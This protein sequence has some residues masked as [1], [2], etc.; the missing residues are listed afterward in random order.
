MFSAPL[1]RQF[2]NASRS[3]RTT[4][5]RWASTSSSTSLSSSSS[6]FWRNV[7]LASGATTIATVSYY[8][9]ALY[10]PEFAHLLSPRA[11]PAPLHPDDPAAIAHIAELEEKLYSLPVLAEHRKREDKDEWYETRPYVNLPEERRVNSLTA[12]TLKGPGKLAIPPLVRARHD[13]KE[14][15]VFIHVGRALC[16]HE[17]VIHGGLLATLLDETLARV[18][19]VQSMLHILSMHPMMH[20]YPLIIMYDGRRMQAYC[21]YAASSSSRCHVRVY[22][23]RPQSVTAWSGLLA[24]CSIAACV[25][26]LEPDR[27]I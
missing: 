3:A 23:W 21:C 17:G 16:G 27:G 14:N 26:R 1:R 19:S 22:L 15:W 9:G 20:V 12:G 6:S 11:A 8:V 10:P 2:V 13:S 18:V 25:R 5:A 24:Q 7:R 4:S